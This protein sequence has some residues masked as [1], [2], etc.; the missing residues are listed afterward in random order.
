MLEIYAHLAKADDFIELSRN[1]AYFATVRG[2][3]CFLPLFWPLRGN[4]ARQLPRK[5]MSALVAATRRC[6][7]VLWA[8]YVSLQEV[9]LSVCSVEVFHGVVWDQRVRC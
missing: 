5:E 1:E 6:T 9:G 3:W 2:R 7:R 8:L 4:P